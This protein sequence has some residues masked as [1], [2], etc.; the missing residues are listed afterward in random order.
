MALIWPRG[1]GNIEIGHIMKTPDII[2]ALK[3]VIDVFERLGIIYSIGGSMASSAYGLARATLD[4]D[5]VSDLKEGAHSRTD[6]G[7]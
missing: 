3:P 6:K 4:I 7:A 1:S 5:M 2:T